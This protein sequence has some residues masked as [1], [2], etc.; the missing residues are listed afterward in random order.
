MKLAKFL[1]I[2]AAGVFTAR[3]AEVPVNSNASALRLEHACEPGPAVQKW[4]AQARE[5][6]Q[7]GTD[8][9]EPVPVFTYNVR[10]EDGSE[11][12]VV[13]RWSEGV[14]ATKRPYFDVVS[15]FGG[16]LAW[17]DRTE[18]GHY[19]MLWPNPFPAKRI[20]GV[21]IEG[22]AQVFSITPI[23]E[24]PTGLAGTDPAQN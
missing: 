19:V 11:L 8:R 5:S 17:A 9:P 20:A 2:V 24:Q 13:V 18:Q 6:A 7:K 22:P 4:E 3:S 15:R 21:R 16:P 12:P 10:Y 23:Q 1:L 14:D